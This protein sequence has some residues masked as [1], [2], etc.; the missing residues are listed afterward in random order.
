MKCSRQPKKCH[1]T[2]HET[3]SESSNRLAQKK[4]TEGYF[5]KFQKDIWV[6]I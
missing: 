2:S 3:W 6:A 5:A 1:L 4:A